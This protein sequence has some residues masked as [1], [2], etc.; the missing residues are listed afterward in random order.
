M[1]VITREVGENTNLDDVFLFFNK[2]FFFFK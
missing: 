2:K 1:R